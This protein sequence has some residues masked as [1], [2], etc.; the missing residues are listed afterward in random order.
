MPADRDTWPMD[1]AERLTVAGLDD[2]PNVDADGVR[3]LGELVG[4][5]DIDVAIGRLRELRELGGLG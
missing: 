4:E 5:S 2:R 1:V 3:V